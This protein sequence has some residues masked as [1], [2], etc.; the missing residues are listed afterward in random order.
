[1]T[2]TRKQGKILIDENN[3]KERNEDPPSLSED[4]S[5]ASISKR[6]P[7][8]VTCYICG[9]EFGSASFPIHEPKCLEVRYRMYLFINILFRIHYI[10]KLNSR[11]YYSQ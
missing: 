11:K 8:T 3:K 10:V 2:P 9:R 5:A 7:R 6:R 1:M 4:K